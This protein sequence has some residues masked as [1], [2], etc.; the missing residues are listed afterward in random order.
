MAV[1]VKEGADGSSLYDCASRK[2]GSQRRCAGQQGTGA[3]ASQATARSDGG[4]RGR[5]RLRR[6]L[7]W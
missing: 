6:L 4:G 2:E 5:R 7:A 3:D 1:V